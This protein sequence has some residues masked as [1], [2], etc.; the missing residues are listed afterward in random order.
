MVRVCVGCV[1]QND[2]LGEIPPEDAE[3]FDV[4]AENAGA[5]VLIQ[6]M[7]TREVRHV[8]IPIS[9][10]VTMVCVCVRC[11]VAHSRQQ[12]LRH[13]MNLHFWTLLQSSATPL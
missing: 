12:Y 11:V 3:I 2:R 6:S 8:K 5:V 13:N 9:K 4:V 7:S 1:V 10:C